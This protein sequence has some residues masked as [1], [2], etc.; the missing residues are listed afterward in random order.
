M[1]YVPESLHI[2][3]LKSLI[4]YVNE[5]PSKDPFFL[6]KAF[7]LANESPG[8]LLSGQYI[9]YPV[10]GRIAT[11]TNV[12]KR[13]ANH[14]QRLGRPNREVILTHALIETLLFLASM[15]GGAGE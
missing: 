8:F 6:P 9:I 4:F 12:I 3:C 2:V 5:E 11:H 15:F 10:S 1:S 13:V 7:S 14:G